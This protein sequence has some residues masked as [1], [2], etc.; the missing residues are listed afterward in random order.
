MFFSVLIAD[1]VWFERFRQQLTAMRNEC[2]ALTSHCLEGGE[3]ATIEF[4][5]NRHVSKENN[6]IDLI[7]T[8]FY[9][10]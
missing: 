5:L 7:S 6:S 8:T 10:I 9:S 3:S 2:L 4:I 1:N